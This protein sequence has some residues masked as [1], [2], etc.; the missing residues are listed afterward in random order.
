MGAVS[1]G[2]EAGRGENKMNKPT[3]EE[4]ESTK[5]REKIWDAYEQAREQYEQVQEQSEKIWYKYRD[6]LRKELNENDKT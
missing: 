5:K 3:K 6:T 4:T 2:T 1:A